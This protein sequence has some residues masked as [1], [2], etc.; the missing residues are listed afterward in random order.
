VVSK[1][2]H[3]LVKETPNEPSLAKRSK[4]GLVTK[5]PKPKSPFK[6]VDEPSNEGVPV[7]E[8][9][10]KEEDADLEMALDLSLMEQGVETQGPACLVVIK[11]LESG[12]IQPLLE[13][14]GKGKEKVFKEQVAHDLLTL[15]TPMK[16]SLAD[17]FIF[18]RHP[19]MPTESSTHVELPSIDAELNLTDSEIESDV[20]A[21]K[22]NA[23]SQDEGSQPPPSHVVHAGPNLEHIDLE[24]TDASN[25]HKPEQ[26]DEGFTTTAYPNVH[27]NLKL[28]TEDHVKLKELASSTGT[29]SSLQNLDKDL[30]FTN[31]FLWKIHMKKIQGKQMRKQR[32]SQWFQSPFI[33]TLHQFL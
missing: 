20:E 29:M 21:S 17:Q 27:E 4:G 11:E 8:P 25:Q 33:K 7:E 10:Y 1:K 16:K 28:P 31:Q 32:F 26:M 14:Q 5:K 24:T 18:Q 19:P 22:I 3:K 2:K 12:R 9:A 6:L 15:Q 30:S 23:G 13:V